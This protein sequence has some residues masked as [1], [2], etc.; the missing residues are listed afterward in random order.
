MAAEGEVAVVVIGSEEVLPDP[1]LPD[2]VEELNA[3]H[4]GRSRIRFATIKDVIDA[5]RERLD[6]SL[7]AHDDTPTPELNPAMSGC[8]VTRI[9]MKQRLREVTYKLLAAE[10]A[11]ATDA[12]KAG[13][14]AALPNEFLTAWQRVT[15]VQFHDAV[16]GTHIDSA[17]PE[18]MAML[19]EA[20]AVADDYL[21]PAPPMP[22]TSTP[23]HFV[24]IE[25]AVTKRLGSL[26]VTFDRTG[27]C[28][29]TKD[30]VDVFGHLPYNALH[31]DFRIG[32]LV[33]DADFGDAWGQRIPA[34]LE[35]DND[36][37]QVQLGDQNDTVEASESAIRWRGSYKGHEPRVNRLAWTVIVRP[38]EDGQR[39][40]FTTEVDWD[41]RSHRLRAVF[42]VASQEA[43]ATWEIPFGF[44]ERTF[45]KTQLDYSQWKANQL[46]FPALHWVRRDADAWG[47]V[48]V[49][50]RGL[51]GYR[52]MPGRLDI[53]LLRSPEWEFCAVEA[54]HYEF[55][56][57]DGQRDTGRHRLEYSL[58]PFTGGLSMG[59]LTRAGYAYAMPRPLKAPF[60]I[61]GDVA[62]TA[63]KPTE[64]ASGWIVRLYEAGGAGTEVA[65]SFDAP[66]TVTVTDLLER[67]QG[68]PVT[69]DRYTSPLHRHGILTLHIR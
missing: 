36:F 67:P 46:E 51:P 32:E 34:F 45:D 18:L 4:E 33:L 60:T 44:I 6:A 50:N 54:A 3:R 25:G 35:I 31:R 16:T 48:A 52:W 43:A 61:S 62:V 24:P 7:A 14:P 2:I 8:Y 27:I 42:P 41:T 9:A 30:G 29:V 22:A 28:A 40:D 11:L 20:E 5:F 58:W 38:S 19:E 26:D 17:S 68:E 59:D 64:D 63:W 12:W 65:L 56:D 21:P 39:L 57:I 10:A 53:G 23:E 37:T 49:L 66:R 1:D 15:F 47:G 69:T 55:W 13:A